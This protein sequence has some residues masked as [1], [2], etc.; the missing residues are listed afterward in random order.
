[1]I[2]IWASPLRFF[3]GECAIGDSSFL[4]VGGGVLWLGGMDVAAADSA[5]E[6][7]GKSAAMVLGP[8]KE[9]EKAK[10]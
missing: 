6:H 5:V 9:Q 4:L 10:D 1:M 2:N 3:G 8:G 7:S